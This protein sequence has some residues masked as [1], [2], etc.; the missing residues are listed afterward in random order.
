MVVAV[1][2]QPCIVVVDDLIIEVVH[3]THEVSR[4]SKCL[5]CQLELT[6]CVGDVMYF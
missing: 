3:F 2:Q 1:L 5:H 6:V 4:C